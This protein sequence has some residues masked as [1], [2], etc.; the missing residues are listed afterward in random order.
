MVA[1][2]WSV[3]GCSFSSVT[4]ETGSLSLVDVALDPGMP[5]RLQGECRFIIFPIHFVALYAAR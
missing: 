4:F 5:P 2:C 3:E 1:Q